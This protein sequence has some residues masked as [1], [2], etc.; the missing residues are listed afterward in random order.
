M[1]SGNEQRLQ[2]LIWSFF[3]RPARTKGT[4]VVTSMSGLFEFLS[5]PIITSCVQITMDNLHN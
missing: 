1:E 4:R 5:Q 2:Q 3:A